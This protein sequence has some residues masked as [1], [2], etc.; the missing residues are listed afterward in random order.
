MGGLTDGRTIDR[1]M[2]GLIDGRMDEWMD[3]QMKEKLQDGG[4]N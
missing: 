2:V 4:M 1:W 3:R